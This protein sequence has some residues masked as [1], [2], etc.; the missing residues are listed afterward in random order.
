MATL[1]VLFRDDALKLLVQRQ[2]AATRAYETQ[3]LQLQN[4]ID[5]LRSLKLIDQERVDR[6]VAELVR[7]QS[8]LEARSAALS[9]LAASQTHAGAEPSGSTPTRAPSVHTPPA[10]TP[11]SDTILFAPPTQRSARLE[12]RALP[13]IARGAAVTEASSATDVRVASIARDLEQMEIAQSRALN[14]MEE[15][16]DDRRRQM[17]RVFADLDLLPLARPGRALSP[18]ASGGPFLPWTR[19][20]DDPFARQVYR[21]RASEREIES[22]EQTIVS[23]PVRRPMT[24]G[25][26][27]TS[28]FGVRMD[29][30][31]RQ[32]ALHTGVDFRGEPGE[33]VRAAAA[34]R[35]VQAER[36]GGYGL[37]AEVDHGN[38]I[39]TRY[40]HL[41]A[42]AVAAGSVVKAGAMIG[43]VGSTGR[44]TGPHLHY[45][46]RIE[47]EPVDPQK[48]L[49]A[50]LR[51]EAAE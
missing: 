38:G 47:G 33:P 18:P 43:R 22:L 32:L 45:E 51:L 19:P 17:R 14:A 35:V 13:P 36:N 8:A 40:A 24:G 30:F 31:L 11:L 34:G 2:V 42:L 6:A 49:R 29:P 3:A 21:I 28:P 7:R 5:R 10:P 20:P 50:G 9:A 1:Y 39:V 41:S 23:V 37:M 15:Q 27:V 16:I 12:S 48:F 25:I 44:S 4:E 46:V 26:E